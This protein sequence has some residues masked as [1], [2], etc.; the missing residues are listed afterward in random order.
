MRVLEAME[1]K[2]KEALD[3]LKLHTDFLK[4]TLPIIL[5]DPMKELLDSGLYYMY[6]RDKSLCPLMIFWPAVVASLKC[7][8]EEAMTATHYVAQYVVNY[9]M[10]V[11][12]IEN[13]LT[14]LDMANL[15]VTSLPRQW[16]TSF[17]KNFNHN[18]YQ[19]NKGMAL[20]NTAWSLRAMWSVVKPFVHPTTR[21]KLMFEGKNSC[22]L[23]INY[24]FRR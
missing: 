17:V 16:I 7:E 8:L 24:L 14:I 22:K 12:K 3:E 11:G 5:T 1:W 10:H 21:E 20:L 2:H 13:W 15:G 19:R 4:E 18:Y 23:N 6:G 9:M